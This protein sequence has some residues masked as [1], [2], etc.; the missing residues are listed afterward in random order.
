MLRGT[1][2]DVPESVIS[3]SPRSRERMK[4][5]AEILSGGEQQM[6]AVAS[7]MCME[8]QVVLPDESSKGS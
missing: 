7:A 4:Q 2:K 6:L 5:R 3:L 8:P 1:S